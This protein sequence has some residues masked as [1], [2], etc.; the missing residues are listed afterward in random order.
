MKFARAFTIAFIVGA[1]CSGLVRVLRDA[2]EELDARGFAPERRRDR[3]CYVVVC[4]ECTTYQQA[5]WSASYDPACR[6]LIVEC[7]YLEPTL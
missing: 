3:E 2:R 4:R 5:A 1:G 7:A 6:V